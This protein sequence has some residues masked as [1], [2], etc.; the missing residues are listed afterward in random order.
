MMS[1]VAFYSLIIYFVTSMGTYT[2]ATHQV[3][4]QTFVMCTVWSGPLSQT[5]Q[6]FMP[7][8]IYGAKRSLEKSR[9][10]LR[11]LV[12]IGAVLGL[13]LGI[14][15]TSIPWLFPKIFTHDPNVIQE[16]HKVLIPYFMALAVT[17]PTHCLEGTLLAGRDLKFL[18]LSMSGCFAVGALL[19]LLV[20]SRGY[21]LPGCWFIFVGFQW[22]RFFLS[23]WHLLS[24]NGILYFEDLGQCQPEKQCTASSS[25]IFHQS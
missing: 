7:E 21:G 9:M 4:I 18:S 14:V 22:V 3:M 10:L 2:I 24:P 15:G 20:T 16:M 6:S 5:A 11:S 17:P 19:L 8:L 1:K 12:I 25:D 23:L 13:L